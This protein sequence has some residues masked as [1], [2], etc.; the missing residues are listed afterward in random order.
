MRKRVVA[1]EIVGE[2]VLGWCVED[3]G[4]LLLGT[5]S[6]TREEARELLEDPGDYPQTQRVVRV[7]VC[8]LRPVMGGGA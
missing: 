3:A 6:R 5:I 2:R 4:S 7:E 1:H 8:R